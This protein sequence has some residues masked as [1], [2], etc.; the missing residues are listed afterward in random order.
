MKPAASSCT[1]CNAETTA[2]AYRLD[3]DLVGEREVFAHGAE[4]VLSWPRAPNTLCRPNPI[5]RV[6][7]RIRSPGL[8]C[9]RRKGEAFA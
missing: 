6:T 9:R 2:G 3:R 4:R 7:D 5:G 8:A 1:G